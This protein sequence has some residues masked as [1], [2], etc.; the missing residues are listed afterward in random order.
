MSSGWQNASEQASVEVSTA[1]SI[2]DTVLSSGIIAMKKAGTND[3]EATGETRHK[4]GYMK[5][6]AASMSPLCFI[7]SDQR[8]FAYFLVT[9]TC[10]L[11]LQRGW[12]LVLRARMFSPIYSKQLAWVCEI[13]RRHKLCIHR[14]DI[15]C[16]PCE[17]TWPT[18][19]KNKNQLAVTCSVHRVHKQRCSGLV[20][21][22]LLRGDVGERERH[23]YFRVLNIFVDL[24]IGTLIHASEHVHA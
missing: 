18:T 20:F 15:G 10:V 2:S 11:L 6:T 4:G 3:T 22:P 17:I 1:S 13:E 14:H 9:R 12:T 8:K 24:L 7:V 16:A 23:A 21:P 5:T 19:D